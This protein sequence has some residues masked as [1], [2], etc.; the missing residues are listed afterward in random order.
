MNTELR[1]MDIM[2]AAPVTLNKQMTIAQALD[3]L[4]ENEIPGMPV[5]SEKNTVVGFLSVHDV[6]VDLWCQYYKPEKVLKVK[7]LMSNHVQTVDAKASVMQVIELLCIDKEQ[8]Y[9]TSNMGIG[10]ANKLS[11]IPL[12]ER[13]RKMQVSLPQILPVVENGDFKGVISRLNLLKAIRTA[14]SFA[15]GEHEV[16]ES[17]VEYA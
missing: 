7:D 12:E 8:L 10:T 15:Q 6:M 9:P 11:S 3:L 5:L 16:T 14:Y 1:V 2:E 4:V 13:A 17:A